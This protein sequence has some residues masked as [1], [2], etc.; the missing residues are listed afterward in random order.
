MKCPSCGYVAFQVTDDCVKCGAPMPPG[1]APGGIDDL[2]FRRS[3]RRMD[4]QMG[5]GFPGESTGAKGPAKPSG[6]FAFSKDEQT[7]AGPAFAFTDEPGDTSQSWTQTRTR[8]PADTSP[9]DDETTPTEHGDESSYGS[10]TR[11]EDDDSEALADLYR[12]AAGF[13]RRAG[14]FLA[15]ALFFSVLFALLYAVLYK[16][17]VPFDPRNP[18]YVPAVFFLLILHAFYC[19]FFHAL[20]GQTPG[21]AWMQIRVVSVRNAGLLSP[22]D[23]F[24]RWVGY[25]LSAFPLGLG[26][27]WSVLDP[28]DRA[29]HDRWAK[30]IVVYDPPAEP[31][32]E[33]DDVDGAEMHAETDTA[34][35]A[36]RTAAQ[37]E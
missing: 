23:A 12:M 22:W 21:K 9:Q 24:V 11:W 33:T 35:T 34:D 18:A 7:A 29:W 15:D 3:V 17:D 32:A 13:G 5:F 2:G 19:T 27:L 14:A 36:T 28:D 16:G 1:D 4:R 26:F 8:N 6:D 10:G 20:T 37:D 30:S 25:F 31:D